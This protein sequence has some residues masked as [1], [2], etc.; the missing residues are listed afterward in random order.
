[1]NGG[2]QRAAQPT[3]PKPAQA[4]DVQ[5]KS[6]SQQPNEGRRRAWLVEERTWNAM[7]RTMTLLTQACGCQPRSA[8]VL[9][10][11]LCQHVQPWLHATELRAPG[12]ASLQ[13]PEVLAWTARTLPPLTPGCPALQT[14]AAVLVLLILCTALF[15]TLAGVDSRQ[16]HY[17]RRA[18][19]FAILLGPFGAVMRW[20]LSKLNFKLPGRAKWF[21]AGTFAANMIAC[22]VDYALMVRACMLLNSAVG[23]Q[24]P[25]AAAAQ[26]LWTGAG[27]RQPCCLWLLGSDH[28]VRD[29]RGIC[30]VPQHGVNLCGRGASSPAS[31]IALL[32][33]MLDS[34]VQLCR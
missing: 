2:A 29:A 11:A 19:W 23:L 34:C 28:G 13:A 4:F 12:A 9:G 7:V 27:I 8:R 30:W 26:Q 17:L 32:R 1:M 14:D 16:S 20:Q 31:V 10:M 24:S 5:N 33:S 25:T 3:G 22:V 18:Q 15:A 21:P 6:D